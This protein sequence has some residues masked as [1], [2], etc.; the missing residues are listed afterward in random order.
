LIPTSDGLVIP[1]DGSQGFCIEPYAPQTRT[2][3]LRRKALANKVAVAQIV[4]NAFA[5]TINLTKLVDAIDQVLLEGE[6]TDAGGDPH[7][8][9]I[10][11][12]A[13]SARAE[14]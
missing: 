1:T 2:R 4:R 12:I 6:D 10:N 7:V 11:A 9:V 5:S 14:L 8:E 13:G 3:T